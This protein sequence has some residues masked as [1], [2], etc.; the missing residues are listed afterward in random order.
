MSTG[1]HAEAGAAV[2]V[3][4]QADLENAATSVNLQRNAHADHSVK[5]VGGSREIVELLIARGADVQA[6]DKMGRT[7]LTRATGNAL[8]EIAALLRQAGAR[9]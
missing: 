8:P 9:E 4:V 2:S 5:T 1:H 3:A 6:R 7:A